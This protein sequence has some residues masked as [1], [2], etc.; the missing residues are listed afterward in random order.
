MRAVPSSDAVTIR[1][2]S[3][4]KAA[5]FTGPSCLN[6]SRRPTRSGSQIRTTPSCDEVAAIGAPRGRGDRRGVPEDERLAAAIGAGD[7]RRHVG[8]GGEDLAAIGAKA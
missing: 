8:G 3:G 4:P 7:A 1:L 6:V 5:L 2:P